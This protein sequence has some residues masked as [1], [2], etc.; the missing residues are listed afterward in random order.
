MKKSALE[1]KIDLLLEFHEK[2]TK[3][4]EKDGIFYPSERAYVTQI[5]YA[6]DPAHHEVNS[7]EQMTEPD[8]AL[9]IR[10]ILERWQAGQKLP[11]N[12]EFFNEDADFDSDDILKDATA[13]LVDRMEKKEAIKQAI[14]ELEALPLD[15]GEPLPKPNPTSQEATPGKDEETK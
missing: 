5:D 7:G 9:T 3:S 6:D 8:Q 15:K 13:D 2:T 12:T 4:V 11:A 10:Q 14:A 1:S